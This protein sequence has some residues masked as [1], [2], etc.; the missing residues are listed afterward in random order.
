MLPASNMATL[1]ERIDEI[2]FQIRGAAMTVHR[3]VGPGC[4]ER[5]YAPCFAYEL[6]K[7]RLEFQRE[8]PITLLYDDLVI[9]RAY[10]A[11]F[12]VEG[13]VVAELKVA[14]IVT[15]ADTAQLRTYLRL[16]GCPVGLLLNF[17]A[18]L[19][20]DGIVRQVNNFPHGTERGRIPAIDA[21]DTVE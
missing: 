21:L 12:I 15:A 6:Q 16:T 19:M 8:V 9:P 3:R 17:G 5:A 10:E 13:V 20:K 18:A 7:R 1:E 4:F 11:D 14:S 2:T